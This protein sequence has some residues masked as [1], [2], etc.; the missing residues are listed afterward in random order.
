MARMGM[1]AEWSL[2]EPSV[3]HR[4]FVSERSGRRQ[5]SYVSMEGALEDAL[6]VALLLERVQD[7]VADGGHPTAV[8]PS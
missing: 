4:V 3:S 6:R 2:A 8:G 1:A 7:H 5:A